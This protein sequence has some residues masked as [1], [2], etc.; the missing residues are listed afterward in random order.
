MQAYAHAAYGPPAQRGPY[1]STVIVRGSSASRSSSLR[2]SAAALAPVGRSMTISRRESLDVV[3]QPGS[4]LDDDDRVVEVEVEVVDEGCVAEPIGVDVHERGAVGEVR[5]GSGEHE[6]GALHRA[7][8][9]ESGADAA[10]QRG[11]A[12]AERAREHHEVAG[13]QLRA[14]LAAER[15]HGLGVDDLEPHRAPPT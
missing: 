12:G 5:V 3:D 2:A 4:P 13:A 15:L 14:E 6:G 11:L 7:A 9:A 8:H 10:G 1:P